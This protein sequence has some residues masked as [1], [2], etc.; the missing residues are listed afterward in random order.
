[1]YPVACQ[2]VAGFLSLIFAGTPVVAAVV[3]AASAIFEGSEHTREFQYGLLG[4]HTVHD[5]GFV[6]VF[7]YGVES[8]QTTHIFKVSSH[9]G[10]DATGQG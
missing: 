4:G 10:K 3:V 9:F 5:G 8:G 7:Q 2:D 1:M 6:V